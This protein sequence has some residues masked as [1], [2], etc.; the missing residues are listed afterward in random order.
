MAAVRD[1][2]VRAALVVSLLIPVYFLVA[3]LGTRFGMLDWTVGFGTMTFK[4]GVLVLMGGAAFALVGLLMALLT[5]PRRGVG[6]ALIALLI[7]LLGIG[8]GVYV[9]QTARTIAPIHDISTDLVDPPGFSEAVVRAR[10]AVTD[11]NDLDLLAKRTRDGRAFID[12]QR[13]AYPDIVPVPTGLDQH[14]AFDVALALARAQ[15]W[16]MGAVDPQAGTIE[17]TARSLWFGFTDDIAIRVRADGTGARIDMRSVSRVGGSDLGANA[18]RMRPF[19]L[20]LRQRLQDAE[21]A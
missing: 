6:A 18:R 5:P 7:P 2:W 4:W 21:S 10:A 12:L 17:A 11:H 14:R 3:A 1:F 9:M 16:T 20:Q 15:H 19:L 13:Q 8:Y